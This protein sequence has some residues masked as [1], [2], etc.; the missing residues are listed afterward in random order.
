MPS[1]LPPSSCVTLNPRRRWMAALQG[2]VSLA[3]LLVLAMAVVV[4]DA[5][6]RAIAGEQLRS[7][8]IQ[9][10]QRVL[11]SQQGVA[12]VLREMIWVLPLAAVS[13]A[14]PM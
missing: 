12:E 7:T 10:L 4:S 8:D 14:A 5:F 9:A 11:E 13:L 1:L 6:P 2:V 3:V